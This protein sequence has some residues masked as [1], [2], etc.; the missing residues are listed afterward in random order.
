MLVLK[1]LRLAN[2]DKVAT[3]TTML[4]A[5]GSSSTCTSLGCRSSSSSPAQNASQGARNG[6]QKR[7]GGKGKGSSRGKGQRQSGGFPDQGQ[8]SFSARLAHGPLDLL[9]S[10]GSA[11]L[12]AA[13]QQLPPAGRRRLAQPSVEPPWHQSTGAHRRW[14]SPGIRPGSSL[15]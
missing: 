11:V 2:S 4:A 5:S 1:E 9:Q 15:R 13:G 7:G 3:G 10:D 8:R 14:L 6:D 12:P